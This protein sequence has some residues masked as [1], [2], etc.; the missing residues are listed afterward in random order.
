MR[1]G[2]PGNCRYHGKTTDGGK[3]PVVGPYRAAIELSDGQSSRLAWS[4]IGAMKY[5]R[6][7]RTSLHAGPC[8]FILCVID[9]S[10]QTLSAID[11]SPGRC[12][13]TWTPGTAVLIGLNSP[14]TLSV[15]AGFR[16]HKSIWLGPPKR[17]KK[18]QDLPR[19]L[20]APVWA[21]ARSRP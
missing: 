10:R 5:G 17:K 12:S 9:R 21:A 11:A 8:T 19:C 1:L 14:R 3:T 13:Q 2:C 15:A 20:L 7:D 4:V 18:T 16:S 6:P